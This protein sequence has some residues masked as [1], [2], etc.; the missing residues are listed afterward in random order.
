MYRNTA[1]FYYRTSSVKIKDYIYLFFAHFSPILSVFGAKNVFLKKLHA[2]KLEK[3][4]DSIPR[5]KDRQTLICRTC[6][7]AVAC[8]ISIV[9]E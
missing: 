9:N 4:N 5:G 8:P 3:I 1:N 6:L 7:G 2:K